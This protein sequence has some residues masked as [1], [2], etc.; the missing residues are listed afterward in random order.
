MTIQDL[1][2]KINK[3][4]KNILSKSKINNNN[5]IGHYPKHRKSYKPTL[6]SWKYD[7][8]H[9]INKSKC[10]IQCDSDSENERD[11]I[12]EQIG[13]IT[14][15]RRRTDTDDENDYIDHMLEEKE[16]QEEKE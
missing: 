6:V 13:D 5:K 15:K 9:I 2:S 8:S 16:Q 4:K 3:V 10:L 1:R 14:I 7:S 11:I 12:Y